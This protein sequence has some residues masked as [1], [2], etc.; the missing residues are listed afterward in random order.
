MR[1]RTRRGYTLPEVLVAVALLGVIGGALSKLVV[2]Q[3]R[4]FDGVTANRSARSVARNSMN[5]VL[6][7]LRMVMDSGGVTA[8]G[9]DAKSITINVPYSFGVFCGTSGGLST[10]SMLPTDSSVLAIARYAGYGWR[11]RT[12]G[13]YTMVVGTSA[14]AASTSPDRC[15]GT[16]A[17]QAGIRTVSINGRT[18]QVLDI[19]PAIPATTALGSAVHF[20]Q[21][22]T[23]SFAAS[24]MFPGKYGLWRNVAG[25]PNEELM[26][27]FASTAR[28]RFYTAGDDTSRTTIPALSDIRGIDLVLT[29]VAAR[30]PA[31]QTAPPQSE[32]VTSVFFKNVRAP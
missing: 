15:T 9:A 4:F 32:M 11:G 13:R 7:D 3:M 27:P 16:A 17:G 29:A 12:S 8:V 20:Y 5:V 18:G 21:S 30:T 22:V 19:T 23:Y 25:G 10:V 26:G 28:F 14:P 31:G 1:R 24:G 2:S 6:S